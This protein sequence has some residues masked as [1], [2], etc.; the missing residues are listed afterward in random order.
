MGPLIVYEMTMDQVIF[1]RPG[2]PI[3]NGG[4]RSHVVGKNRI[5][6]QQESIFVYD[7]SD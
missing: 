7:I 2:S 6:S 4:C 3:G 5:L 1:K